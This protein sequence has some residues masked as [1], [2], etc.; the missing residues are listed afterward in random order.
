MNV[1]SAPAIPLENTETHLA[2]IIP[3]ADAETLSKALAVLRS[4]GV[5]VAPTDTR[6]GLLARADDRRAM[7]KLFEVKRRP[8]EMV[9]AVFVSSVNEMEHWARVTPAARRLQDAF[10]PGPLTL[11]MRASDF[12]TQTLAPQVIRNNE[13]GIRVSDARFM[14]RLVAE[15]SFPLTATS[16]NI[17]G[18]KQHS[19]LVGIVEQFGERVSLYI[20]GGA[21][22]GDVSTVA[23]CAEEGI[24]EILRAGALSHAEIQTAVGDGFK[25]I[26]HD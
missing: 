16:A 8:A 3:V 12:A 22:A 4:G 17:S 24:V 2:E 13:V 19:A 5:I 7:E 21:L 15:V 20:D 25:V 23:R 18:R 26:S 9:S 6:Y 11:V 1:L 14:T 10:L